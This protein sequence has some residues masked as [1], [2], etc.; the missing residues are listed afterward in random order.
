MTRLPLS[1]RA[2]WAVLLLPL[3]SGCAVANSATDSA[4]AQTVGASWGPCGGP[5]DSVLARRGEPARRQYAEEEDVSD[6]TKVF[7]QEWAWRVP[8]DSARVVT[9]TWGEGIRRC[10]VRERTLR[11]RDWEREI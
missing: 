6:K 5:R 4:L 8:P 11:W 1:R 3:L 2:P 10:Q 9:F 7:A